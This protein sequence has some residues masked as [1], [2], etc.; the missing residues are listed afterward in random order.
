MFESLGIKLSL[1]GHD[2]GI[3]QEF[4]SFCLNSPDSPAVP[5]ASVLE[6]LSKLIQD[7]VILLKDVKNVPVCEWF[8]ARHLQP[9]DVTVGDLR[10]WNDLDLIFSKLPENCSTAQ[11]IHELQFHRRHRHDDAQFPSSDALP[12]DARE[13]VGERAQGEMV[14]DLSTALCVAESIREQCPEFDLWKDRELLLRCLQKMGTHS[15]DEHERG[16][17]NDSASVLL[18][19][20]SNPLQTLDFV[21][22][23]LELREPQQASAYILT[24]FLQGRSS[25]KDMSHS[26]IW[27]AFDL[28][29]TYLI[30]EWRALMKLESL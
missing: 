20:R 23:F 17:L 22:R 25:H 16:M 3:F 6:L 7:K 1:L 27:Q 21:C 11:W 8:L 30:A 10:V 15:S 29:Q 4:T 18:F 24:H 26:W 28:L 5:V 9:Q 13:M 12:K 14:D 19:L 2:C